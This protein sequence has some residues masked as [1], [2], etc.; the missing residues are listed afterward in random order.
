[1]PASNTL[2]VQVNGQPDADKVKSLVAAQLG[3]H[4]SRLTVSVTPGFSSLIQLQSGTESSA[5]SNTVTIDVAKDVHKQV[6]LAPGTTAKVL[7]EAAPNIDLTP[8]GLKVVAAVPVTMPETVT[9]NTKVFDERQS[10]ISV[11]AWI[12]ISCGGVA[13][14]AVVAVVT[15]I[16]LRRREAAGA[17]TDV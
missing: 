8:V 1:M 12:G 17:Y 16:L 4:E 13:F 10:S 9:A 11:A 7:I 14:V 5:E 3:I 15:V 2:V 6:G